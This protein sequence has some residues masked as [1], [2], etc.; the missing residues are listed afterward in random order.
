MQFVGLFCLG[1]VVWGILSLRGTFQSRRLQLMRI[2][3]PSWRFFDEAGDHAIL[4][5]QSDGVTWVDALPA[6]PRPASALVFNP[7]GNLRFAEHSLLE[8]FTTDLAETPP[9]ELHRFEESVSYQLVERLA[10][11]SVA[12]STVSFAFRVRNLER[13]LW[14]SRTL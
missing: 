4:E 12:P 9:S 3:I 13:V 10:R 14:V 11:Q 7:R 8:Q 6:Q 1:L 5:I 2:L